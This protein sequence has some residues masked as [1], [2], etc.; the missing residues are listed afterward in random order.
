MYTIQSTARSPPILQLEIALH[1]VALAADNETLHRSIL[2]MFATN[3]LGE[4]VQVH[5]SVAQRVPSQPGSGIQYRQ[6]PPPRLP[7]N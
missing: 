7:W 4:V 5:S 1:P 6:P 3:I 2:S